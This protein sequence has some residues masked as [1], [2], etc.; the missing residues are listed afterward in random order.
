MQ[1]IAEELDLKDRIGR[2]DKNWND[3]SSRF[4]E[5]LELANSAYLSFLSAPIDL[6]REMLNIVTSNFT[7]DGKSVSIKLEN[8]F[9]LLAARPAFPDGRAH[10]NMARTISAFVSQLLKILIQDWS[11]QE[12]STVGN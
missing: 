10:P 11:G 9:E 12:S 1:L 5:F 2:L 7:A 3:T 4:E 8:T 6:K